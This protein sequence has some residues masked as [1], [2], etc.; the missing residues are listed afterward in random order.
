MQMRTTDALIFAAI[1]TML[2][3]GCSQ[4]PEE[5][6]PFERAK[7]E[8][9]QLREL[10]SHHN[11]C[12]DWMLGLPDRTNAFAADVTKALVRTSRQPVSVVAELEDVSERNGTKTAHFFMLPFLPFTGRTY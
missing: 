4:N 1:I 8:Q 10:A 2:V 6:Q 3:V 5:N 9:V 11:A 7:R 12:S